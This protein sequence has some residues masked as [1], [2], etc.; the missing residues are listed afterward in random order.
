MTRNIPTDSAA[1]D[2]RE[3]DVDRELEQEFKDEAL[4]A[5]SNLTLVVHAVMDGQLSGADALTRIRREISTLRMRGRSVKLP[6]LTVVASRLEDYVF[7]LKDL[8]AQHLSGLQAFLDQMSRVLDGSEADTADIIRALPA[9]P[10][11]DPSEVTISNIEILLVE[12]QRTTAHIVSRELKACGYRVTVVNGPFEALELVTRIK[13]DMVVASAI[14]GDISGIDLGCALAAM[15]TT[16][17][18]PF[19]LLTSFGRENASLDE[20]PARAAILHKGVRFGEDLA[21]A[22]SR[23][24]IT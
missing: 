18:I 3:D 6:A 7:E 8:D 17:H 23:L 10:T 11:F 21:E 16:R 20:L 24:G 9:N 5:V 4:D 12:P 19:A 2:A 22:L 15:P 14:L 1:L 13:P